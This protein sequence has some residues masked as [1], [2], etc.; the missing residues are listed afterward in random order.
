MIMY[1]AIVYNLLEKSEKEESTCFDEAY[2]MNGVVVT[3]PSVFVK[4]RI[5]LKR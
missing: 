2:P 4:I 5:L 3:M 1:S